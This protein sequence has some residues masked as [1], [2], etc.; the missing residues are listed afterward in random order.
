MEFLLP[1]FGTLIQLAVV[2]GIIF[3]IV[4]VVSRRKA[5]PTEPAGVAIGRFF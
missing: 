1:L 3:L 5:G 4:R 2:G